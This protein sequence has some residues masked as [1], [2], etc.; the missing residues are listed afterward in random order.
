M[1]EKKLDT[2]SIIGIVLI[3]I[4]M[5]I[6]FYTQS[7]DEEKA[8]TETKTEQVE[9]ANKEVVTDA[10]KEAKEET[11]NFADSTEVAKYQQSLGAFA[12]SATLP[13]ASNDFTELSNDKLY[14]KIS[15][16]GGQIVEARLKEFST[17]DSVPVY[18]I[19]DGNAS[20][21]IDFTTADNRT[22]NTKELYFEP[23]T[24]SNGNAQVVSMKLKTSNNTYLEYRYELKPDD[25]LVDFTVRSQGLNGAFNT[26]KPVTLDWSLN[27]IRHAKS[28]SY[29]N[30]YTRLTYNHEDGKISKLSQSGDDEEVEENIKWLSFRQHFFSSILVSDTPFKT[31]EL[32]SKNLIGKDVK[33]VDVEFLK[34]YAAELPLELSGG[35]LNYNMH[36]YYGPTDYKVL[37]D[38]KDLG[39]VDSMPTGWGIFGVINRWIIIPLFNFLMSFL[40][41]GFAIIA[42]T[43]LVKL[44]LSPVQY[45]QFVSQAKMKVLRPEMNEINEKYEN[46]PMKKQQETMALYRKAG[47]NPMSGCLP[48]VLQMPVFYALFTFFPTAFVLRQKSFL[49]ADDLSSYDAI[50]KLPFDIPFYGSHVSLFPI[51]ASVAIFIYM[52]MTSAQSMQ[53]QQQPG[54][55]NMKFIL[56]LSPV[57]MLIFFNN[58]ASGLSLY[59]FVSNTITIFI[60]LAIKKFIIDEDKIHAKIQENKKKPK[61]EGKFQQRLKQMMEQAEAQQKGKKK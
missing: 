29:E 19:K 10:N 28:A 26:S 15:N 18:L 56:Y 50:V 38:Y 5:V 1:E 12:Y 14:L 27:G 9:K 52:Q 32:T 53:Q 31:G 35:E 61:K 16:K 6:M 23:T 13:S 47:V 21:G 44:V 24:S 41:A 11:I 51:L 34:A 55:P 40:P 46:E 4:L 45:K 58:Y 2:S 48:A 59:Y 20:F 3:G 43:I 17:Y 8:V 37:N 39:I 36:M 30:R 49:W 22:L 25:Y 33:D 42:L 7:Q 60:M 54:M 57:M